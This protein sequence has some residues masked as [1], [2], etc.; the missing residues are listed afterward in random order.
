[1]EATTPTWTSLFATASAVVTELGGVL[2]HAAV[3]AREY[4]LPAIVGVRLAMTT[5]RDGQMLEVDGNAGVV[6]VID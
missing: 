4:R 3:V 6:R 2:S 1:M 5:L